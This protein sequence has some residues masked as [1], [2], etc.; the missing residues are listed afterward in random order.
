MDIKNGM[1]ALQVIIRVGFFSVWGWHVVSLGKMFNCVKF[2]GLVFKFLNCEELSLELDP[3]FYQ[4][5]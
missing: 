4:F 1:K 5:L 2:R 3:P